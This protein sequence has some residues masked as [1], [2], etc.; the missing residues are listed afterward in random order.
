MEG[1]LGC[2]V[3]GL[4]IKNQPFDEA[5]ARVLNPAGL[6]YRVEDGKVVLYPR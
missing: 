1:A 5:I 4:S 3:N 2:C 6:R